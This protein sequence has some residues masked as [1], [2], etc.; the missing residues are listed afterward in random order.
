MDQFKPGSSAIYPPIP[1]SLNNLPP[2]LNTEQI[3]PEQVVYAETPSAVLKPLSVVL[4]Y[5]KYMFLGFPLTK[6][7]LRC[8]TIYY[9]KQKPR[10]LLLANL[11]LL[12]LG[13]LCL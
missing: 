3:L 6:R 4:P 7:P 13:T 9:I 2:L 5:N 8:C 10:I 12:M 11:I 1:P